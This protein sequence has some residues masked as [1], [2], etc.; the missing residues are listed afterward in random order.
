MRARTDEV[1]IIYLYLIHCSTHART[2]G[3]R[4]RSVSRDDVT[5]VQSK[6]RRG[7]VIGVD[8]D[9]YCLLV[10]RCVRMCGTRHMQQE[11]RDV[12]RVP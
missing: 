6:H 11:T 3:R 10:R 2:H 8:V 12:T 7:C 9:D 4:R 1:Y 5:L